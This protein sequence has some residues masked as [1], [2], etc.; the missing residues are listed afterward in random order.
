MTQTRP[1]AA[2]AAEMLAKRTTRTSSLST[3]KVLTLAL[4]ELSKACAHADT[5]Q[6]VTRVESVWPVERKSNEQRE[7][8]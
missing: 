1:A 4:G 7:L 5:T 3:N 8:C 6:S 2:L